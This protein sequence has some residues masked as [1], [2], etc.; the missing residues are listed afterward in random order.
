MH[1]IL[2][3][4]GHWVEAPFRSYGVQR[5]LRI[6]VGRNG[7]TKEL[8]ATD[9]HRWFAKSGGGGRHRE[10]VTKDLRP[11]HRLQATFPRSGVKVTTPSPFGIAHGFTFGDGSLNGTGSMAQLDPVQGRAAA[12]M[13]PE[14]QDDRASGPD[15]RPPPPAV[16]QG[17]AAGG[18]VGALPV[19]LAGGLRRRGWARRQGR[20]GDAALRRPR[21]AGRGP[22]NLHS[23]WHRYVRDHRAVAGGLS[24]SRTEPDLSHPLRQRR[25]HRGFLPPR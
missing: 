8:Y 16:L 4:Q 23:A 19:R 18:R 1:R 2:N 5:L 14:Q 3:R 10:V 6:T 24:R 21:G 13:V 7:Q 20:H 15:P 9:E 25:P 11:G 22:D 17:S 12:Q